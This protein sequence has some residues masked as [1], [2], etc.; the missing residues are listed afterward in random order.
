MAKAVL[1]SLH[2]RKAGLDDDGALVIESGIIRS[3][4]GSPISFPDGLDGVAAGAAAG[5]ANNVQYNASG[6]FGGMAGTTWNNTTRSLE[7]NW[8]TKTT[9]AGTP[10]YLRGTWNGSGQV[11]QTIQ[12][13]VTDSASDDASLLVQLSRNTTP[14]FS[15]NKYG[16]VTVG[17]WRGTSIGVAYGGTGQAGYTTGDMLYAPSADVLSKLPVGASNQVLTVSSGVPAWAY[18]RSAVN[19]Q[20][21]AYSFALT[22]GGGT[23]YHPGSDTTA[24]VW[25][26]PSNAAV[27]FP[28]GTM[29]ALVNGLGAGTITININSDT[30]VWLGNGST[31][32]RTFASAS[33]ATLHKV[34]S[35]VWT[36]Q[37]TGLS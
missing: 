37:G 3:S 35:T 19:A 26:I 4:D 2:G 16:Y 11:F 17:E 27:A 32:S 36:I 10:L 8:G 14:V 7:M 33:G 18:P 24:R 6:S 5:V 1:T 28:V 22:D 34:E 31:G 21:T 25:T 12:V 20:S 9:S 30:L 29:I 13:E 23:V 15:V